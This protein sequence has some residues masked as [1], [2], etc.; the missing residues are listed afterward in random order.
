MSFLD[1]LILNHPLCSAFW[2]KADFDFFGPYN[3][4]WT[5]AQFILSVRI[6]KNMSAPSRELT[7]WKYSLQEKALN[8][9]P[10][11]NGKKEKQ[12]SYRGESKS[13]GRNIGHVGY[14]EAGRKM[15]GTVYM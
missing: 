11:L 10:R 4:A 3:I 15:K 6:F 14:W 9:D 5:K 13:V 1:W 12:M 2:K 8:R 7:F